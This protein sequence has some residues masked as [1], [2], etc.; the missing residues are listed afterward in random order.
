[1]NLVQEHHHVNG[2]CLVHWGKAGDYK[3]SWILSITTEALLKTI[4]DMMK[5]LHQ[6]WF[7]KP[8][9]KINGSEDLSL[10]EEYYSWVFILTLSATR[11]ANLASHLKS[12]WDS[13]AS[14]QNGD[15]ISYRNVVTI[16]LD[17][18]EMVLET[19]E[20]FKQMRHQ[21]VGHHNG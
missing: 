2:L 21:E 9:S 17:S 13:A 8:E 1:M 3:V 11:F 10:I 12:L 15:N 20:L 16:K 18:I 19:W 4:R 14:L 7:W 5:H 6:P